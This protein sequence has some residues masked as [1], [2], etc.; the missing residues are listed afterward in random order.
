MDSW[1]EVAAYLRRGVTT[2]QRWEREEGLPIH[3]LP[4]ARKGSVFAYRHELD[5]WLTA[6][7][8]LE[9]KPHTAA[10]ADSSPALPTRFPRRLGQGTLLLAAGALVAAGMWALV[11][12]SN[13]EPPPHRAAPSFEGTRYMPP[14][15]VA[16]SHE[17][18]RGPSVSPDG[19]LVAFAWERASNPGIFVRSL[20]DGSERLVWSYRLPREG[21]FVTK[22]SPSGEWI[23]F[24]SREG[25]NSYGLYAMAPSG[26]P[27]T[28]LTTMAGVGL[29]WP[30]DSS[31]ITFADRTSPTEPFSLYSIALA[32][33]IRT[34][35]TTPDAGTFGDTACSWANDHR[36]LA[37]ARFTTRFEA[38]VV[39]V[40]PSA[41]VSAPLRLTRGTGGIWDL[42]WTPAND[43]VLFSG[44]LGLRSVSATAEASPSTLVAAGPE[45]TTMYV[46]FARV[47]SASPL[48]YQ[49]Q[50]A[51]SGTW[52]WRASRPDRLEPWG[53]GTGRETRLAALSPDRRMVTFERG[54]EVWVADADG[55]R[56]RQLT[57]HGSTD[58]E[59]IVKSPKW[60][61]DGT[62]VAF[63]VPVGD[64]RDI[65]VVDADG[66]RSIRLTSEPSVED[67]PTWSRD[68]RSIYFRSDRAGLS[69]IWKVP[70]AGGA[71]VR[72]TQGEGSQALESPDG[73]MLYFVRGM[74]QPG[75]WS[76]PVA[77]GPERL[78]SPTV[79]HARWDL[80]GDDV[81]FVDE[82]DFRRPALRALSLVTGVTRTLAPLPRGAQEGFSAAADG[83]AVLL[84]RERRQSLD[85]MLLKPV[86]SE[87]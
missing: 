77:G 5:A 62:R 49:V 76:M 46:S 74:W 54:R 60:S 83:S 17:T 45:E 15:P 61:P 81:L 2:V 48:V 7:A 28:R 79:V 84:T 75:L 14:V 85:V 34:R 31:S 80:A 36:R 56:E 73:R 67:N 65:Y 70:V 66:S 40:E 4:H 24:A 26:G 29:C 64:H 55:S 86:P 25:E 1:K 68:G 11:S 27:A 51:S 78:V 3:R 16:A 69:H 43:A 22:W 9:T 32:T 6:R 59:R 20:Q 47:G 42:E 53:S 71:A 72:V 41:D 39:I 50:R 35:L 8:S 21:V 58:A 38:D 44:S 87:P 57:F 13:A 19:R 63:S 12:R 18:E 30:P 52:L 10:P 82:T 23:A 33:R 37:I